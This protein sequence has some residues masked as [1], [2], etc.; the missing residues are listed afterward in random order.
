MITAEEAE[1][2]P[3]T[4]QILLVQALGTDKIEGKDN[5]TTT[6][7]PEE[8]K[9]LSHLF[10]EES[11]LHAPP[12]KSTDHAIET[13]S[14]PPHYPIYNMSVKEEVLRIYLQDTQDNR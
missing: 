9:D 4:Y 11:A 10:S 5:P 13:T 1:D 2:Q 6:Q 3:D 12:H 8:L 14:D 7:I